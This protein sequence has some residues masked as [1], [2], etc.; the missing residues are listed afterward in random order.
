MQ[1]SMI[2]SINERI[3]DMKF[4]EQIGKCEDRGRLKGSE[5]NS[6]MLEIKKILPVGESNLGLPCDRRGYLPLY[7]RRLHAN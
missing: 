2:K 7:F 6:L 4:H 5:I 1:L 3:S